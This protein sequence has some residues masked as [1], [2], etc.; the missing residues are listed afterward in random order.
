MSKQYIRFVNGDEL[1]VL[2]VHSQQI[3]YNGISRDQLI[4]LF[5]AET[6][7]LD[8][9]AAEFR[10]PANCSTIIIGVITPVKNPD[11]DT[12]TETV[13]EFAHSGYTILLGYG[14]ANRQKV[15]NDM[16]TNPDPRDDWAQTQ[17]PKMVNFAK[18]VRSTILEQNVQ[19]QGVVLKEVVEYLAETEGSSPNSRSY[20]R[21]KD[22]LD[23]AKKL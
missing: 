21:L 18:L 12:P 7:T 4:F 1:R 6:T 3:T 11:P 10:D 23:M 8:E 15:I 22:V 13:E 16:P 17:E 5:D 20:N 19:T 9:I 14:Y 2:G